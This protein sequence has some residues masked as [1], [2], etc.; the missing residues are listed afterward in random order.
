MKYESAISRGGNKRLTAATLPVVLVI[1]V[2]MLL[3]ILLV[4]SL[5]EM[6]FLHYSLY[7][8]QKQ[9]EENLNS[10]ITLYS[11]DSTF[12]NDYN[13]EKM[14]MILD[15]D[16]TST[17]RCIV[18]QWGLYESIR[19]WSNNN[20]F[21]TIKLLGKEEECQHRA[22]LWLCDRNRALSL[23]GKT[24][25]RGTIFVPPSGINYMEID[26]EHYQGK[27][28]SPAHLKLAGQSLPPID[29]L[30]TLFMEDLILL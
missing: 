7:L 16:T 11:N 5:W 18:K 3:M 13:D 14:H 26:G 21:S 15:D 19:V 28:I 6:N 30:S 2:L 23:S 9:Q 25:V 29:S 12:L 17:V 1:S 27:K 10:A 20:K 4:Y 22:A 8:R 24:E